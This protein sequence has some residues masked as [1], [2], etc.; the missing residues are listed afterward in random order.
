MAYRRSFGGRGSRS[1]GYRS[2]YRSSGYRRP[3]RRSGRRATGRRTSRSGGGQTIRLVIEGVPASGVSRPSMNPVP[4]VPVTR[5]G[6]A[7][8]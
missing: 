3:A 1:G 5:P 2:S 7:K 8:L 6:K 4:G